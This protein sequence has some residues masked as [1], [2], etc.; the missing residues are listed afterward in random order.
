MEKIFEYI[1][2]YEECYLYFSPNM[3]HTHTHTKKK[4]SSDCQYLLLLV[5][6]IFLGQPTFNGNFS[7]QKKKHLLAIIPKAN[8]ILHIFVTAHHSWLWILRRF[9]GSASSAV[10]IEKKIASNSSISTHSTASN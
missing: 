7:K 10:K 9:G 3:P 1:P 2:V 5:T 4:I 8:A 6:D